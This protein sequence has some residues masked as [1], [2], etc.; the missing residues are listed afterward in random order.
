MNSVIL[1]SLRL[2][3]TGQQDDW[4]E[5]LPSI[6]M[7]YRMTP[8]TQSTQ[9][10]PFF[11]LFGREMR[12]PID[13]SLTPK[14]TLS[15]NF[16]THLSNV[17]QNLEI[18]RKIAAE[19]IKN[20][21][22]KYKEQYDK[23]TEEPKYSPA[24]R[25]WLYCTKVPVGMAPKLHKKCV[26]PYYIV[27]L[28]PHNTY[29]LRRCGD[30]KEVKVLVNATRLKPYFDP[31]E[32][33]TNPPPGYEHLTQPLNAEHIPDDDVQ[34]HNIPNTQPD[35]DIH[36]K[37][38]HPKNPKYKV[39]I[40][41]SKPQEKKDQTE[42][43][44]QNESQQNQTQPKQQ[45]DA[46]TSDQ[47]PKPD[48]T[49]NWQNQY[50]ETTEAKPQKFPVDEIDKII[51]SKRSNN[52]LYY[53]IKWKDANK[54]STWEYASTIPEV[55]IRKYHVHKTMSGRK[56]KRPLLKKN[57]FFDDLPPPF[58]ERRKGEPVY[59]EGYSETYDL[60]NQ[61]LIKHDPFSNS[62]VMSSVPFPISHRKQ[63]IQPYLNKLFD[64][65]QEINYDLWQSTIALC[66][67]GTPEEAKMVRAVFTSN[68]N[69]PIESTYF[70]VFVQNS[71]EPI[72]L[73]FNQAP[74]KYVRQFLYRIRAKIQQQGKIFQSNKNK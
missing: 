47:D 5:L 56:R 43:V 42:K 12:L 2:Y 72:W 44:L 50:S 34:P 55:F 23:R 57:R 67:D 53:R 61:K 60:S 39:K 26:G 6:M 36:N 4:P 21:Q 13:T 38:K 15:A 59:V 31:N 10:S 25:V 66:D 63:E 32:R 74:L 40:K 1:Q 18:A 17:L 69:N 8:A 48:D 54:Q 22:E 45:K 58:E 28:G 7:A 27:Y 19:N 20:A 33:P 70:K 65:L 24:D 46:S 3:C 9:H 49:S 52:I 29:K 73:P 37:G 62:T 16:K 11:L 64:C 30:N 35:I 68:L 14:S 51:Q 41:K 71:R